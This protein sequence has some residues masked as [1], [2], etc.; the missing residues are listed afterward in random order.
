[1]R[2][3]VGVSEKKK[4]NNVYRFSVLPIG[5]NYG[6]EGQVRMVF[7]LRKAHFCLLE[8][9]SRIRSTNIHIFVI[10]SCICA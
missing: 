2:G 10:R 4:T 6:S 8:Y 5:N 3:V 1:M 7:L 9:I